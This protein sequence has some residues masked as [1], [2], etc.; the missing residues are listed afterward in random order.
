MKDRPVAPFLSNLLP[1][2]DLWTAE[3]PL[4]PC[5]AVWYL[6]SL[7]DVRSPPGRERTRLFILMSVKM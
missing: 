3:M 6:P 4:I 7:Y 1:S 5:H 2:P